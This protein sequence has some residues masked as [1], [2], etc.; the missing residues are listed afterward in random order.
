MKEI[1]TPQQVM[2]ELG[3]KIPKPSEGELLNVRK[4]PGEGQMRYRDGSYLTE[5]ERAEENF[6]RKMGIH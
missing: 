4:K 3:I 1:R 2:N 5:E 6:T